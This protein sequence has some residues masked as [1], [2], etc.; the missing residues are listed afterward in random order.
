MSGR[1]GL[2]RR[3]GSI[4]DTLGENKNGVSMNATTTKRKKKEH[5]VG[6]AH[7]D[8]GTME[9]VSSIMVPP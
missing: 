2:T 3:V 5:G 1:V 9:V 6:T 4:I 8:S 7:K